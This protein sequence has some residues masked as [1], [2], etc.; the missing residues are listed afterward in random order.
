MSTENVNAYN[1][2]IDGFLRKMGNICDKVEQDIE[3]LESDQISKMRQS[4]MTLEAA[5][6]EEHTKNSLLRIGIIGSVKAG[7]STFLNALLFNGETVLP[8]AATPM[9][10][11]LTRLRHTEGQQS[12]RFIFYS[13]KDWGDI[14]KEAG[15]AQ[16]EIQRKLDVEQQRR[17]KLR[18]S[19]ADDETRRKQLMT[20]LSDARRACCE[21][22]DEAKKHNLD[23]E[24]LLGTE[25]PVEFSELSEVSGIL[26][27]YIGSSGEMTAIVRDVELNIN[28]DLLHDLEIVDTP[29]LNDPVV[30]RSQETLK[31][32]AQCDCVFLL[33]RAS[34]FLPET[35]L[36]MLSDKTLYQEGIRSKVI[37]ASQMD[38]ATLDYDPR[39]VSFHQ[40]YLNSGKTVMSRQQKVATNIVD[41]AIPISAMLAS[42]AYKKEQRINLSNGEA[43]ILKQISNF[44]D[45]P[46]QAESLRQYANLGSIHNALFST[47]SK[48]DEIKQQHQLDLVTGRKASF[49]ETLLVLEKTAASNSR[50]LREQDLDSLKRQEEQIK[51]GINSI[52]TKLASLFLKTENQM[53]EQINTLKNRIISDISNHKNLKVSVET[54]DRH[55][56]Y[57]TGIFFKD[58]RKE[59]VEVT[60]YSSSVNNAVELLREY[61]TAEVEH[62]NQTF[63]EILPIKQLKE[64]VKIRVLGLYN[65]SGIEFDEETILLPLE[66]SL[67]RLI[68]PNFEFDNDA[69]NESLIDSF[70]NTTVLDDDINRLKMKLELL[71]QQS[72]KALREKLDEHQ[73]QMSEELKHQ[74]ANFCSDIIQSVEKQLH[75]VKEQ[76]RDREHNLE[77][78]E[79]VI[80]DLRN[81]R[82]AITSHEIDNV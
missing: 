31:A 24:N 20:Q 27:Q 15:L 19:K 38:S 72:G 7:K 82:K 12:A 47:R 8:K 23:L 65:S 67:G 16:E 39:K 81:Y 45:A 4:V 44:E 14:E 41:K 50:L 29:G 49:L 33:S 17:K 75:S 25:K 60:H 48:K 79:H 53:R 69:I 73:R 52:N 28:C 61:M 71:L 11:S 13:R 40:A 51:S 68:V 63:N 58:R 59:T 78:Y 80:S 36:R 64:Q 42:C 62:I 55:D 46:V 10:A 21:L 1:K 70:Y 57:T 54:L 3:Y 6:R 9:T 22:S 56:I 66:A 35:D 18:K 34:S 37:V 76:M 2:S 74:S 26:N 43:H 77:K 32:L 5:L 30:S